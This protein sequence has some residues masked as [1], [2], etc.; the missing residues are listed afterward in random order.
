MCRNSVA[1]LG[2]QALTMQAGERWICSNASCRCECVVVLSASTSE[3]TNPRCSCGFPMKKRYTAP[4]IREA[5][6]E[7]FRDVPEKF[8]SN[9]S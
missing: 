9:A 1:D 8:L 6:E 3:G 5:R 4:V 7:E 2:V